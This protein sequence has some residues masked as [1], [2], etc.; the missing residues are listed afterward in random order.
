M[1]PFP[2]R[3]SFLVS[4]LVVGV[5]TAAEGK[6]TDMFY[7]KDYF[8]DQREL[9]NA[10]GTSKHKY[11]DDIYKLFDFEK[12]DKIEVVFD[13]SLFVKDR[14]GLAP[15]NEGLYYPASLSSNRVT[16]K[17]GLD[18]VEVVEFLDVQAYSGCLDDR[19]PHPVNLA[20][21]K[22]DP[23][24]KIK[25]VTYTISMPCRRYYSIPDSPYESVLLVKVKTT[26]GYYYTVRKLYSAVRNNEC[27]EP[28]CE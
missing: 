24:K 19:I 4:L 25:E 1:K 2:L 27:L 16:I 5:A 7:L 22:F 20:V 3:V 12:T 26:Q 21:T 17:L 14:K 11:K 8:V 23:K 9:F 15:G 6:Y 28:W 18:N 13:K 10:D